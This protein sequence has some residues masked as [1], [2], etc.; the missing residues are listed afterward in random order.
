MAAGVVGAL[1][2]MAAG[3]AA[4]RRGG[5]LHAQQVALERELSGLRASVAKLERG[6]PFLPEEAV[7]VSVAEGVVKEFLAAQL[8]IAVELER[9]KIELTH[10]E[11]SF[12]GSPSVN[13]TGSMV[14]KDHPDFVGEVRVI[15]ALDSITVDSESGSLRAVVAVDHVDLLKIGGLERFLGGRT[16]DEL[17]R[18]V[19]KQLA[20]RIPE[21][22]I[23][24]RI[25]QAIELPAVTE[26][27]V[28]L[29]AASM[30]LAVSVADVV[31]GEGVL[32]IAVNV[33]PGELVK[34]VQEPGG[35]K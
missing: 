19:R 13:L 2:G 12:K 32:W 20:G 9:S 25:E 1:F 29:R 8:P 16:V 6:E 18:T 17:A 4:D 22:Q 15:G 7:V 5:E 23:P 26:G 3:C 27:P 21:V 34:A 35:R 31:A 14:H 11:A 10:A 30:P 33:V 24:V 28:R